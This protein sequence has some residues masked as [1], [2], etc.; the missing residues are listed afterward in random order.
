MLALARQLDH[1]R[2]DVGLRAAFALAPLADQ[3]ALGLAAGKLEN[4]L[5]DEVIEQDDVGRL[6]GANGFQGQQLGIAGTCADQRHAAGCSPAPT[7][8]PASIRRSRSR[9]RSRWVRRRTRARR[10]APRT[11]RRGAPLA[12]CVMN[13]LAHTSRELAPGGE[14]GRQQRLDPPADRLGEDRRGTIGRDA[15]DDRRAIDDG[16]ELELAERR[17]V[18]DVDRHAGRACG[19]VERPCF[20]LG[21]DVGQRDGCAPAICRATRAAHGASSGSRRRARAMQCRHVRLERFSVDLDTGA[22]SREQ[23]GLPC[24]RRPCRQPRPRACPRDRGT[25]AASPARPCGGARPQPAFAIRAAW[26]SPP[27]SA[28]QEPQLVPARVAAPTASTLPPLPEATA[29]MI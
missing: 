1:Q 23:L 8:R 28:R 9:A 4:L 15:D 11:A 26:M 29:A 13:A 21:L 19:A 22:G 16:A 17:L 6:Q 18:D 27:I 24:R 20:V 12:S 25:P 2:V 7:R 3:H 14:R 5:G 10:T